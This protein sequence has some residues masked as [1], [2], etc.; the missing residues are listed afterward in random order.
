MALFDDVLGGGNCVT[1]LAIG[2]G[3]VV[4]NAAGIDQASTRIVIGE[5]QGAEKGPR[6]FGIGPAD[7]E[8]KPQPQQFCGFHEPGE[9]PSGLDHALIL[10]SLSRR[11]ADV[12]HGP[13]DFKRQALEPATT[14]ACRRSTKEEIRRKRI[15]GH[16]GVQPEK[17]CDSEGTAGVP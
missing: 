13:D 10:D 7:H 3:A 8:G 9:E 17:S 14:R 4:V 15:G 2:V 6:A 11:F 5:Q 12:T 16:P 1:G